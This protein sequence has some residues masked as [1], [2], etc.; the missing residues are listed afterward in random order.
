MSIGGLWFHRQWSNGL[1]HMPGMESPMKGVGPALLPST[2]NYE[3]QL[4]TFAPSL[5]TSINSIP[6]SEQLTLKY[7]LQ[8]HDALAEDLGH[9]IMR[10]PF[11]AHDRP[12]KPG[13]E[14]GQPLQ[15]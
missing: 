2:S 12:L 10:R 11:M 7:R 6:S 15:L 13:N 14:S 1:Y 9:G 3:S 4:R 8:A 5:H